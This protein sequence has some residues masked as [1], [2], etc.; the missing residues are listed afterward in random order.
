VLYNES[1]GLIILFDI[2]IKRYEIK[3]TGKHV[4]KERKHNTSNYYNY[5]PLIKLQDLC[6]KFWSKLILYTIA[7]IYPIFQSTLLT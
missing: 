7:I 4:R 3:I 2:D 5:N 6:I 1:A